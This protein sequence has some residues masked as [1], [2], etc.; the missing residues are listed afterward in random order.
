MCLALSQK[1]RRIDIH[2]AAYLFI[3]CLD[4]LRFARAVD[5]LAVFQRPQRSGLSYFD[6]QCHP[7]MPTMTHS[8][9]IYLVRQQSHRPP[10][11]LCCLVAGCPERATSTISRV[12]SEL[13]LLGVFCVLRSSSS[14]S[15][16][17][18]LPE[19]TQLPSSTI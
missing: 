7:S 10:C 9:Q 17:C 2:C 1:Y 12:A 18:S 3:V 13:L 6:K 19:L 5:L 15:P 4:D 11:P 14:P 8:R 16:A